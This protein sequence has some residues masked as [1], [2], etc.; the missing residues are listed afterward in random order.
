M[1]VIVAFISSVV[2]IVLSD[3]D[4]LFD[5]DRN[6]FSNSG[7]KRK[8]VFKLDKIATLN[9]AIF[10]GEMGSVGSETLRLIDEKLKIALELNENSML[11]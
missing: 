10:S 8:S 6:D 11:I 4:L 1:D 3:T 2:P 5:V 7:L 9:K